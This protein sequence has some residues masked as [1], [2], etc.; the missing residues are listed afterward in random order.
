MDHQKTFVEGD[1]RPWD[2]Y[3]EQLKKLQETEH[4]NL[5]KIHVVDAKK[6]RI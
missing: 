5:A 2:K 3:L 4:K 1:P 6:C